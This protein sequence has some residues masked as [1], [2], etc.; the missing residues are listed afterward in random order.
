MESLASIF[1][2]SGENTSDPQNKQGPGPSWGEGGLGR[3]KEERVREEGGRVRVEGGRGLGKREEGSGERK[4]EKRRE[5]V[6]RGEREK[7]REEGG[8]VR[9]EGGKD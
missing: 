8:R 2:S 6:K 9:E 3:E 7:V 1:S 4:G 5:R